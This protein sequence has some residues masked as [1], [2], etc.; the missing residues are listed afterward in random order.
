M[1]P[2]K[3]TAAPGTA[4]APVEPPKNAL[5]GVSEN[6][7]ADIMQDAGD[8]PAFRK[9]DL[10]TPFLR[11]L[12]SNSPQVKPRDP[13]Q[14]EGATAGMFFNTASQEVYDGETGI[15][16]VPVLFT[17][18]LTEWWPRD[19]APA[20]MKGLVADHGTDYSLLNE[21]KAAGRKNDKGKWVTERGTELVDGA[22]YYC[23]L[24]PVNEDGTVNDEALPEQVA[25]ILTSTQLK[26]ARKWNTAMATAT[27]RHPV[28]NAPFRPA[29]FYFAYRIVT[30]PEANAK[31]SWFGVSIKREAETLM[32]PNGEGIYDMARG[33][34]AL[35]AAGDVKVNMEAGLGAEVA[36]EPAAEGGADDEDLPY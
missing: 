9:E 25:F 7:L 20:G 3:Q 1:P 26:H 36:T 22:L 31:G 5:A 2:K 4:V 18:S 27:A 15:I 10:A 23:I 21:A 11:V 28:T 35:F 30:V 17:P 24:V 29:P 34:K 6:L 8:Q 19:G 12:Q 14:I 13:Q 16:L 33:F 32:L